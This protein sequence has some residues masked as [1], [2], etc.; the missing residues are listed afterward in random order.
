M[1]SYVNFQ[2]DSYYPADKFRRMIARTQDN[3]TGFDGIDSFKPNTES[4]IL[5]GV[6][7]ARGKALVPD[8]QGG[9]YWVEKTTPSTVPTLGISEGYIILVV[10]DEKLGDSSNALT[11]DAVALTAPLPA[12]HLK[13]CTFHDTG[14]GVRVEEDLRYKTSGQFVVSPSGPARMGPPIDGMGLGSFSPGSQ[15]TNLDDGVRWIKNMAG[16]WVRSDAGAGSLD[17]VNGDYGPNVTLNAE[18]V[19]AIPKGVPLNQVNNVSAATDTAKFQ[20]FTSG[21]T[22][23]NGDGALVSNRAAQLRDIQLGTGATFAG[24]SGGAIAFPNVTSAPTGSPAGALVFAAGGRLHFMNS[25]SQ[26]VPLGMSISAFDVTAYGARGNGLVDDAPAIQAA[27]NAAKAAGGG[28]VWVPVGVYKL[29]TLPLRIFKNT[30]LLLASGALMQRGDVVKTMLLNGD[31]NA[32]AYDGQGYITVEGG[33]WDMRAIDATTPAMCLSFGHARNIRIRNTEIRNVPGFHAIEFNS[34]DTGSVENVRFEGFKDTGSRSFSEA[35]QIDLAKEA[36]V[37]GGFGF[38]DSTPCRFITISGCYFGEGWG[39]GIGSHSAVDGKTH[40]NIHIEGNYFYRTVE[41]AISSYN[42]EHVTIAGN[43]I[44]DCGAGIRIKNTDSSKPDDT[45]DTGGS[46]T[47]RSQS[48]WLV[49]IT[50]NTFRNIRTFAPA[51]RVAGGPDVDGTERYIYS[52]TITGNVI[53]GVQGTGDSG[54]GI[55]LDRVIDAVVSGNT[56][57]GTGDAGIYAS[58]GRYNTIVDNV[59]RDAADFGIVSRMNTVSKIQ[60]NIVR[61]A[62][63]YGILVSGGSNAAVVNNFVRDATTYGIRV[64]GYDADGSGPG[65]SSPVAD[66]VMIGNT[67]VSSGSPGISISESTGTSRRYG[68]DARGST[69]EDRSDVIFSNPKDTNSAP[70]KG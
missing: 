3:V 63:N 52:V 31:T 66:I 56:I 33:A 41:M 4:M 64:S 8:G 50:G 7:I 45:K 44:D 42:W 36:A 62:G 14:D 68:N 35:I 9:T 25:G 59:V 48:N 65:A 32:Y 60:G 34:I 15:Y 37:F 69:I 24:A 39:R 18:N 1:D 28:T 43:M 47:N 53:Y 61:T 16:T 10:L 46:V 21:Y 67:T 19:G 2:D 5:W 29:T 57:Q 27:L 51:I 6:E 17:S 54:V 55:R 26:P 20:G 70:G 30:H 49:S 22:A 58:F 12:R 11:I 40:K 38:Y 23:V 13:L